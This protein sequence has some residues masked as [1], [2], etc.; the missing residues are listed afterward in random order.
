MARTESYRKW[1]AEEVEFLIANYD[2]LTAEAIADALNRTPDSIWE[3]SSQEG[4]RKHTKR[5]ARDEDGPWYCPSCG[6]TKPKE[7]FSKGA[8]GKGSAYCRVCLNAK[9][10]ERRE[11]KKK[12]SSQ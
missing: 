6:K 8:N 9:Q 11:S 1:S 10:A 2:S 3:K 7:E 12:R 5:H 4:L